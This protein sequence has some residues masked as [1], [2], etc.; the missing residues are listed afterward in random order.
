MPNDLTTTSVDVAGSQIYMVRAIGA[1]TNSQTVLFLHGAA[2]TS[3]TWLDNGIFEQVQEA[4]LAAIAIDLPGSGQSDTTSLPPADFLEQL[5]KSIDLEPADTVIVSPSMSGGFSLPA[6][7]DPFFSD[8][9]GY[10]PVAPVGV[11]AFLADSDLV[12]TP[13]LVMWGDGDGSDPLA[14]ATTLAAGFESSEVL[15]IEDA[16]HAAYQQQPDAFAIALIDFVNAH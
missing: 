2:F 14:S 5:F 13:A 1:A 6:L 10:V 15:I 4:G 8:L 12:S 7:R 3:Q 11:S 16:G 9:A